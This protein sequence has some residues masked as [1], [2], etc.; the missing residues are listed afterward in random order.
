MRDDQVLQFF[1]ADLL[2]AAIDQVLDATFH[3][4]IA[5]VPSDE[6]AA[7]VPSVAGETA[8][9]VLG[10]SE[11]SAQCVRPTREQ[12]AGHALR[13]VV[14]VFVHNAYFVLRQ[15]RAALGADD[16][17]FRIVESRVV[18]Q[19]LR[20]TKHLLK[21]ASQPGPYQPRVLRLKALTANL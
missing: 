8:P 1:R 13:N 15:H 10:R 9:I 7:A 20:H 18:E 2:A 6:V 5:V 19:T 14:V 4:Q 16:D 3:D 21:R 17:V 12:F 11:V